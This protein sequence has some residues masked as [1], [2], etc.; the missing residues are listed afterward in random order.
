MKRN[1]IYEAVGDYT[2]AFEATGLD[3]S[4]LEGIVAGSCIEDIIAERGCL[5]KGIE[6]TDDE[7]DIL[8]GGTGY[9]DNAA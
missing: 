8:T 3:N 9:P 5:F 2:T 6:L 4:Y 1:K 7:L